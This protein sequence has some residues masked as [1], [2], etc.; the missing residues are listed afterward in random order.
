[1]MTWGP[2][3]GLGVAILLVAGALGLVFLHYRRP[4]LWVELDR[5]LAEPLARMSGI[6][7]LARSPRSVE[8]WLAMHRPALL[9]AVVLPA[10][11]PAIEAALRLRVDGRSAEDDPRPALYRHLVSGGQVLLVG[12]TATG[13]SVL[14]GMIVRTA[15]RDDAATSGPVLPLWLTGPVSRDQL[16]DTAWL[17]QEVGRELRRL[18]KF[19]VPVSDELVASLL[20]RRRLLLVVD[21]VREGALTEAYKLIRSRDRRPLRRQLIVAGLI[22]SGLGESPHLVQTLPLDDRDLPD[23]MT[24]MV[25]GTGRPAR[26]SRKEMAKLIRLLRR[27]V[28][29]AMGVPPVIAWAYADLATMTRQ[30]RRRAALPD[31]R[32]E[33]ALLIQSVRQLFRDVG[34]TA[35][36]LTRDA[37]A[38]AFASLDD[39]LAPVR[40][41]VHTA[42]A[43]MR[44]GDVRDRL[45]LLERLG[46]IRMLHTGPGDLAVRFRDDALATA[47]AAQHVATLAKAD[48]KRWSGVRERVVSGESDDAAALRRAL[49][50]LGVPLEGSGARTPVA[51]TVEDDLAVTAA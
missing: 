35:D 3:F 9:D 36:D 1:M 27:A 50:D 5:R 51:R 48:D 6:Q 43:A 14:A 17:V 29:D 7:R 10:P 21:G 4:L 15:C 33:T 40:M 22:A 19:A 32:S 41:P 38:L 16:A 31:P 8:A 26:F 44:G 13:T 34:Y 37:A 11:E 20:D 25:F 47:L 12:E 18:L 46:V 2:L 30:A 42:L 23:A 49:G 45:R 39:D 28:P 24:G